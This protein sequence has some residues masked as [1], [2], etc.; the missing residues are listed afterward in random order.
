[1]AALA[2]A[3]YRCKYLKNHKIPLLNGQIYNDIRRSYTGGSVD[4]FIPFGK[5]IFMMLIH[6][7][8]LK[9]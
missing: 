9:C 1:M 2:F 6:Y 5:D 4:M 7:I 3:I 8:H